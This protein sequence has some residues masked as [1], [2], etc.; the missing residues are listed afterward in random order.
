MIVVLWDGHKEVATAFN[1]QAV[2]M[3]RGAQKNLKTPPSCPGAQFY[4][5]K[6]TDAALL[7]DV[8][9]NE[10]DIHEC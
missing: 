3:T 6:E 1:F 5:A 7:L 8:Y 9:K 4:R 10:F 2:Q